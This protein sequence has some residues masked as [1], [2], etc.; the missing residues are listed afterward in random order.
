VIAYFDTSAFVPMLV[1][2][3]TSEVCKRLWED[4]DAVATS[5]LLY[6]EACAAVAQALRMGRLT[7]PEH[8]S[9]VRLLDELWD[10][11][12]V[13]EADEFTT[14]RAARIARVFELRGYDA[15]HCA[16]AE[17]FADDD[18]VVASGDRRLLEVCA[19]LSLATA[20]VTA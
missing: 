18:F 9:A 15:M 5:R 2:E 13:V 12:E 19:R 17:Q 6:V 16:S 4:A 3:P 14:K 20:D 10:A 1:A 8:R 11:F 7:D